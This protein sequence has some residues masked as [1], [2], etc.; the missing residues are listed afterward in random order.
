M[1][2]DQQRLLEIKEAVRQHLAKEKKINGTNNKKFRKQLL[3]IETEKSDKLFEELH[4]IQNSE[5]RRRREEKAIVRKVTEH[6][7]NY[8]HK[9][10]VLS[11]N[12][13]REYIEKL[14]KIDSEEAR[15]LIG[16]LRLIQRQQRKVS[17]NTVNDATQI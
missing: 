4:E 11:R 15:E 2:E 12:K 16:L 17:Y 13:N 1:K 5:N 7:H 6:I 14:E 10:A 3:E 8:S 9:K